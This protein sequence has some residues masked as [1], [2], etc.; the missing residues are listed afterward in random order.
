MPLG[1]AAAA[2]PG[3][4][5]AD[6]APGD[7]AD[8]RDTEG[9]QHLSFARD[10]ILVCGLQQPLESSI[11]LI[12]QLVDDVV[13]HLR[14]PVDALRHERGV[15]HA[16]RDRQ[17]VERLEHAATGRRVA[18]GADLRGGRRL[19]L[20]Q[21]I[22][23]VVVQ[24]HGQVHV[25]PDRVDPVR[26]PDRAAVAVASVDEH[27]QVRARHLDALGERERA[28]VDAVE[29]VG[30]HVVR[31]AAR[32]ADP[33]HEHRALRREVLV[34][35]QPLDRRED[36]VVAASAAPARHAA[37]VVLEGVVFL[38]QLDD[39]LAECGAHRLLSFARIHSASLARRAAAT[40]P[41]LIG[42]PLASVQQSTSTRVRARSI[43]ASGA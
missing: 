15:L 28:A 9:G 11:N 14:H 18:L 26:G 4:A 38:V 2:A 32:A 33:G 12:N 16:E 20:R 10:H 13:Q 31:E 42:W 19:L 36:R 35:A 22:D 17:R 24:D 5:L 7:E 39:E 43:I 30:L 6:H 29:P 41:G 23:L 3:G 37:L 25:V 1:E 8:A 21:A 34:A 40:W 27:V